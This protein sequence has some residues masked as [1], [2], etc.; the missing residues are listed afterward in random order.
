MLAIIAP[1][2][3]ELSGVRRA[4]DGAQR[5]QV[6]LRVIGIGRQCAKAGVAAVATQSPAAIVMIGFCGAA[7][8]TLRAGDLHVADAFYAAEGSEPVAADPALTGRLNAGAVGNDCRLV[9]GP[10]VTVGR[11]ADAGEKLALHAA[12]GAVSVNMED[13]WAARAAAVHGVP[14]A[15]VRAVLDGAEDDLPGFLGDAGGSIV[16]VL[17][18]VA[19]HP[20][21]LPSLMRLAGKARL[22]RGRLA[23]CIS[24]L[25][26]GTGALTA[27]TATLIR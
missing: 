17:R 20:G 16:G 10:S 19:A 22:A 27:D 3:T 4:I 11:V 1:M 8:P 12:T 13:Y 6:T 26:E 5:K 24:G 9:G 7:D 14:F 25:I 21:S 18:G 23:D 2:A 15:S